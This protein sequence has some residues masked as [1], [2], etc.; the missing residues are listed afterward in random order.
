[1]KMKVL[2]FF[3][4]YFLATLAQSVININDINNIP[5]CATFNNVNK[6]FSNIWQIYDEFKTTGQIWTPVVTGAC[7][8]NNID[9]T[10]LNPVC[11]VSSSYFFK[12]FP[13]RCVLETE[14]KTTG[15]GK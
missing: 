8:Q 14:Q 4:G 9:C 10:V 3:L 11:A 15:T 1:M 2:I 6:T 7:P 5:I 13:N 12:T